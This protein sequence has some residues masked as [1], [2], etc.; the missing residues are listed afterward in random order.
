MNGQEPA[1]VQTEGMDP[2]VCTPF[3]SE[4]SPLLSAALA[5]ASPSEVSA[6][7]APS[8]APA[9]RCFAGGAPFPLPPLSAGV[10][11]PWS[12]H[13]VQP[14]TLCWTASQIFNLPT[15]SHPK[16]RRAGKTRAK[17]EAPGL[18]TEP[19]SSNV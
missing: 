18:T 10:S 8:L 15:I 7:R 14:E 9:R 17:A 1:G 6:C 11:T 16:P 4:T 3:P 19:L 12:V 5:P 2:G 13:L